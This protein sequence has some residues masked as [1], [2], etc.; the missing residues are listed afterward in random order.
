MKGCVV[1][2]GAVVKPRITRLEKRLETACVTAARGMAAVLRVLRF[3]VFVGLGPVTIG[4]LVLVGVLLV[5]RFL[6]HLWNP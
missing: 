3:L 6:T 1:P 2:K 4:L 5:G